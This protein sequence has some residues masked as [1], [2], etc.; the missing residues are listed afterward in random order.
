M[1]L[2]QLMIATFLMISA[3]GSKA[4]DVNDIFD[5]QASLTWVGLDMTGAIFIGDRE[6]F[7]SQSDIQNLIRSWNDVLEREKD[8]YNVKTML[9]KKASIDMKLDITRN[10]NADLDISNILSEKKGD[11]IHLRKDGIEQIGA[12]YN[13]DGTK[14]I[15]L[16]FNVETFSKLTNEASVW[17]TFVNMETG[18]VLLTERVTGHPGGAGIRNYWLGAIAEIMDE[19]KLA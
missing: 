4:Q 7:G 19:N 17:V 15:G 2:K 13:F 14:G 11:A 1:K 18:E 3:L 8:K 10:H 12:A 16:M 9:R 6:K 5:P